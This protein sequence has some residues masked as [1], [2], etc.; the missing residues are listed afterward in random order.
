M[1]EKEREYFRHS[2]FPET[3]TVTRNFM[4]G[5][6]AQGKE[7]KKEEKEEEENKEGGRRRR[8][9]QVKEKSSRLTSHKLKVHRR[10]QIAVAK[11]QNFTDIAQ[12]QTK[13]GSCAKITHRLLGYAKKLHVDRQRELTKFL[14]NS[15]SAEKAPIHKQYNNRNTHYYCITTDRTD[16]FHQHK[17]QPPQAKTRIYANVYGKR[18]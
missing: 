14:S 1:K 2:N 5:K 3:K 4:R 16:L 6:G 13:S 18:G 11:Y 15:V 7:L 12:Q 10:W 8:R 17:N 9:R